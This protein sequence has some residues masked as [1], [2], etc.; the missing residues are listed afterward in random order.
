LNHDLQNND[1]QNNLLNHRTDQSDDSIH[2]QIDATLHLLGHAA[3]VPGLEDRVLARLQYAQP[4]KTRWFPGFPR[5]AFAGAAAA[6]ACVAVIAGS[7]SYSHHIQP[8][9]PGVQLPGNAS[10]GIGAASAAHVAPQPVAVSPSG[11]PRSVR[12]E[13]AG[14]A[15]ISPE[16][17]KPTGVAVP[18]NPQQH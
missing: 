10:S 5:M 12:K 2:H 8:V 18:K 11:R 15:V 17:Q 6:I 1:L 14:R 3:P 7:V 13:H 4:V 16:T 9:A